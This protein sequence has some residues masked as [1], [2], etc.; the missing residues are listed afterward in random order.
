M[1]DRLYSWAGDVLA[2]AVGVLIGIVVPAY[3]GTRWLD[4]QARRASRW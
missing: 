4:R 3:I 2:V 1:S